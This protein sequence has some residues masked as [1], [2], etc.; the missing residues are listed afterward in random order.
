MDRAAWRERRP[1]GAVP[2]QWSSD[3]CINAQAEW[4]VVSSR[5]RPSV[6]RLPTSGIFLE[7][8]G[9]MDSIGVQLHRRAVET[10][11]PSEKNMHALPPTSAQQVV[12]AS[13]LR[14]CAL[15]SKILADSRV[16][17]KELSDTTNPDT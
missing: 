10:A 6:N 3:C 12:Q 14:P 4:Q 17:P 7:A 8:G 13:Q 16:V 2:L 5:A 15:A 11:T 9:G 1:N